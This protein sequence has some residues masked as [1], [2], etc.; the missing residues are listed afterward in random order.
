M[1]PR[2]Y[3]P[4][5]RLV[6][7][8]AH[9][10]CGVYPHQTIYSV[11]NAWKHFDLAVM[12]CLGGEWMGEKFDRRKRKIDATSKAG[13]KLVIGVEIAPV[14]SAIF[15]VVQVDVW[16]RQNVCVCEFLHRM[17]VGAVGGCWHTVTA[18][19]Q[20]QTVVHLDR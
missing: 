9:S 19:I 5:N 16:V 13:W 15:E 17:R 2:A 7:F 4:A 10:H 11:P 20:Q 12:G 3:E 8:G 18:Q 1:K 6:P 14:K